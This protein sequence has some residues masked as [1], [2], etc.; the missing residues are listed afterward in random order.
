MPPVGSPLPRARRFARPAV[1]VGILTVLVLIT[2][3]AVEEARSFEASF[4][5]KRR[6]DLEASL[7]RQVHTVEARVAG[8]IFRPI[9][10]EM[11]RAEDHGALETRARKDPRV[12]AIYVWD[13]DEL[14]FPLPAVEADVAALRAEPCMRLPPA[15]V[16]DPLAAAAAYERCYEADDPQLA[17]FALCES[18]ELLLDAE[19]TGVATEHLRRARLYPLGHARSAALDA[20]LLAGVQLLY[21]RERFMSGRAEIAQYGVLDLVRQIARLDGPELGRT[22][23]LVEF[24]IPQDLR[25]YGA[26]APGLPED[27]DELVRRAKR[28]L[29]AWEE[30]EG[31]S[32]A[33]PSTPG[34]GDFPRVLVDPLDDP[35]W[36]VYVSG[37]GMGEL[38]GGIQV[39]QAELLAYIL[40]DSDSRYLS[41]RDAGGRVLRGTSDELLLE[42]PFPHL[43]PHLKLGL[44]RAAIAGDTAG[45]GLKIRRFGPFAAAIGIGLLAL[46]ALIRT[47]RQQEVLLERQRDFVARVSHELK[48]PLA[49]IRL[50]AENLEMGAFRDD[51]QREQ[52]A[53]RIVQEAERLSA[54]VNE[55]IR[56][57]TRPEDDVPIDTDIDAMVEELVAS[58]RPRFQAVGGQLVVESERIGSMRVMPVLLRDAL[59]NLLDNAFKYRKAESGGRVWLRARRQGRNLVVEVEDDG[60]G[61]PSGQ[62]RSI[63]ERFRRVEGAGRG[64]S[65]GHGLGLSFVADTARL[66]GGKVECVEGVDG[67]AKFILRIRGKS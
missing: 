27:A 51:A 54:R 30:L 1:Y 28:R 39:D 47:D 57:A 5:A 36:L 17:L 44:S 49:G 32:V 31:V 34:P 33:V 16:R 38:Y 65:G 61:V 12:D 23:D 29:A 55:V 58:W 15:A 14:V 25:A 67:G 56:A 11:A 21:A 3:V 4:A 60:L 7:V 6:A 42:V 40:G 50:M 66:H 20:R 26:P 63:F 18:A 2:A 9:F 59:T 8:E 43:L 37:L 24:P 22:L 46:W 41:I 10:D 35:P 52:F 64:K 48:T 62:R 53:R 13:R 45:T 19:Q